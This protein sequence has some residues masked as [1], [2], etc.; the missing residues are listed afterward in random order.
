MHLLNS[1]PQSF[2][3][4]K[5]WP[6]RK[7]RMPNKA[8]VNG[9]DSVLDGYESIL[10]VRVGTLL[11]GAETKIPGTR[12]STIACATSTSP[13]G[14]ISSSSLL[15]AIVGPISVSS[16]TESKWDYDVPRC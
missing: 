12:N 14:T 8:D 6:R 11:P 5:K 3:R 1:L 2:P 16:R 15:Y 13:S 7:Q 10:G 4:K 9:V